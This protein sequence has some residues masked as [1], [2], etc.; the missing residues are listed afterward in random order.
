VTTDALDDMPTDTV[1]PVTPAPALP[2]IA[3]SRTS[4]RHW[5]LEGDAKLTDLVKKYGK[6]CWVVV[7]GM[8]SGRTNG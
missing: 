2:R 1:T 7:A 4:N 5:T 8:V 6:D 3:A